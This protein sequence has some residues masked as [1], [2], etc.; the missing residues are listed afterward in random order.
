MVNVLSK[1][2][3]MMALHHLVE[4]NTL[5]STS[6]LLGVHRDTIGR[7]LERFGDGCQTLLDERINNLKLRHIQIDETWTFC[8]KK[9]SRLTVDEKLT[10]HD[11]G[12]QYLWVALDQDTKLIVSH[13]VGKRSGDN[14]RKLIRDLHSRLLKNTKPH[15]SDAHAFNTGGYQTICQISTDM[16][17]VY[18]EAIDQFFGPYVKYGQIRKE[19]KNATMTYVPSEMVGTERRPISN[20]RDNE[21]RTICTSHIERWNLTN[22]VLM[23]RFT[24][25]G[26]GFSKS[27]DRLKAACS[28]FIAYYDFC[29]RTRYPDQSGRAGRLRPTAAMMAGVT[30]RLWKFEDLYE[31]AM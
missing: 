11:Q 26:L 18:P 13:V 20:I 5:R 27:L 31:A 9:Q 22:R 19:Y 14:A 1:D 6:R 21:A 7:L 10:C 28:V 17:V 3:Q 15:D 24:R 2:K 16:Y 30:D 23:K 4:G 8:V 12:D 29:W 25:L